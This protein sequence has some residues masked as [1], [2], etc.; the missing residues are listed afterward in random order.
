MYLQINGADFEKL[1]APM[2][3]FRTLKQPRFFIAKSLVSLDQNTE[4]HYML[5]IYQED[6]WFNRTITTVVDAA[7]DSDGCHG[8]S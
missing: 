8:L 3:A 4:L 7:L 6:G 5:K 2:K 1:P